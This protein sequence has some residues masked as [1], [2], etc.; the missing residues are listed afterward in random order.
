LARREVRGT[1]RQG[2]GGEARVAD[3]A[4]GVARGDDHRDAGRPYPFRCDVER[5]G[6]VSVHRA[7]HAEREVRDFDRVCVRGDPVEADKDGEE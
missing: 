1:D 7:V 2:T 4:G 3:D 6:S 5:V